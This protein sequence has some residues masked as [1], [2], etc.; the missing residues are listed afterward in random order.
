VYPQSN[1]CRI[2]S[3]EHPGEDER[4]LLRQFSNRIRANWLRLNL[5][6]WMGVIKRFR[7][8]A[9]AKTYASKVNIKSIRPQNLRT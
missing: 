1:G 6:D 9:L 2:A 5:I 7:H 4:Q 8:S 3:V